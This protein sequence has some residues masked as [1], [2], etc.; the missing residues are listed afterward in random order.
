MSNINYLS[1][2]EN[3]P[4][5]GADNDTQTFRDN[6]DTI[7]TSL[8]TTKTE[9]QALEDTTARLT[10]P[11]GGA[12]VNDFQLNQ[13]TRSVFLNNREKTNNLGTV[14]LVG[15]TVTE[16][17]FQTGSYFILAA[18]SA[19]NLNF[20]NLAGDPANGEETATQGGVSKITLEL[21]T[22]GAGDRAVTFT[23][24]GGTVIKKDAN[25]PVSL[26]LSS[27]TNPTFIEVWRHD[28]TTIFMKYLGIYS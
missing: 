27:T 9:V 26:V 16:I 7:K 23:T 17:D 8:Q 14:P 11:G 21:R 28:Q 15:G 19:L 3:F 25:F 12:Y 10:N 4:V 1:I 6:F 13:I 2:N 18:S 24:T 22:S 5:A 20:T